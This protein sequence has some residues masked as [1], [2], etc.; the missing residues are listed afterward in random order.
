M[1]SSF[2]FLICVSSIRIELEFLSD[3]LYVPVNNILFKD[4]DERKNNMETD[5][6]VKKYCKSNIYQIR[7]VK[8]VN[9]TAKRLKNIFFRVVNKC[10]YI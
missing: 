5:D 8:N 3:F 7:F 1:C 9:Q 10:I 2:F 6:R 4:D